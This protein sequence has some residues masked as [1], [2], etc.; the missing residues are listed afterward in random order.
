M[1]EQKVAKHT[2]NIVLEISKLIP[3][4]LCS[5]HCCVL[6]LLLTMVS[7]ILSLITAFFFIRI[8]KIY[9]F[10]TKMPS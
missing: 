7:S 10:P 5:F 6:I 2:L 3:F 9:R 8:V 1:L 4:S